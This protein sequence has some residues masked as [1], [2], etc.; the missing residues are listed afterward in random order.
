MAT[1]PLMIEYMKRFKP[2]QSKP[3]TVLNFVANK[4]VEERLDSI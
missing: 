2:K 3:S 1:P 4:I